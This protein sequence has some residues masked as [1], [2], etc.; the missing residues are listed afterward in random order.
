MIGVSIYLSKERVE[1]Q[2]EWLKVAKENGFC[3]FYIT[4]YT[5]G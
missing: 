1:K 2:E 4:S 3:L 5:R